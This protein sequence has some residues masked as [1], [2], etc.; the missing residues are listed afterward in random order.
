MGQL[1]R[2]GVSSISLAARGQ[3]GAEVGDA[4]PLPVGGVKGRVRVLGTRSGKHVCP[5]VE[6]FGGGTECNRT[7]ALSFVTLHLF[8]LP[9]F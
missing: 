6:G 3:R 2:N 5:H 7:L 8:Q 1:I 9:P 4:P